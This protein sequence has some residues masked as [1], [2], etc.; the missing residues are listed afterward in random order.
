LELPAWD[1]KGQPETAYRR[2]IWATV[3]LHLID[4]ALPFVYNNRMKQALV[5]AVALEIL[6]VL[7]AIL[8][9]VSFPWIVIALL[10]GLAVWIVLLLYNIKSTRKSNELRL[11][12]ER[13][14]VMKVILL[15]I[16]ITVIS[17]I[18]DILT[19]VFFVQ[20][21][22]IPAASMENTLLVGDYIMAAKN[23]NPDAITPGDIIIFKFPLDTKQN[24]MKRCVAIE[25]QRMKIVNKRVYVDGKPEALPPHAIFSDSGQVHPYSPGGRWERAGG[26]RVWITN[27]R[28]DNMPDT[29]VP[30]GYLFV[31]GDNRDN[32]YDSRFWGFVDKD[33]VLGRVRYIHFSWQPYDPGDPDVDFPKP[34]EVTGNPLS[35]MKSMAFNIYYF[36]KRVRWERLGMQ[37][38]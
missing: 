16:G 34:P 6:W 3:L 12:R 14:L 17:E 27:L 31:L 11:P 28:R 26:K 21:Y 10:L 15:L 9:G 38:R 18:G 22:R 33:L 5:L 25:R 35:W 37:L 32:S 2:R 1:K 20:A 4:P 7:L 29:I 8:A 24:Y 23:I 19:E 13:R 36:S 30:D